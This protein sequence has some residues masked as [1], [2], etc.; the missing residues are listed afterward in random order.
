MADLTTD[1]KTDKF[2]A[3]DTVFPPYLSFPALAAGT[4]YAGQMGG[5]NGAGYACA[6]N[7]AASKILGRVEK[8]V[9]N[10]SG[11]LGA[12]SVDVRPGAYLWDNGS[13][14]VTQAYMYLACYAENNHTVGYSSVNGKYPYAG[15]VIGLTIAG[16]VIV[17]SGFPSTASTPT[18]YTMRRMYARGACITNHSLTAFTVG[19]NTDGITYAAGDVVLLLGQTT[20]AENGPY[21]VGTVSTTAPLTRVGW[22]ATGMQIPRGIIIETSGQGTLY[23]GMSFKSFVSTGTK[24]VGTDSPKLYPRTIRGSKTLGTGT[25]TVT[26]LSI[27]S[28]A[29]VVCSDLTTA[30]KTALPALTAG[31][32]LTGQIAFTGGNSSDHIQYLIVNW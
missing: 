6:G 24:L 13:N 8:Q 29:M 1:R 7:D 12:K 18:D 32:D 19:T 11:G 23:G 15:I 14:A 31:A 2:G 16:Q 27:T 9:D 3:D 25:G 26:T 10:S 17:L 22:W 5:I 21:M 20:V 30:N 28:Q 4:Y